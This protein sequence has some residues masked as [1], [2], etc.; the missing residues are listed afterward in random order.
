MWHGGHAGTVFGAVIVSATVGWT[1][2]AV[3][4][5]PEMRAD[6]VRSTIVRHD[7]QRPHINPTPRAGGASQTITVSVPNIVALKLDHSGRITSAATN[8][9]RAPAPG[10]LV[11]VV[12]ADGS[13]QPSAV[14]LSGQRW[15]GDFSTSM[16]F[17]RQSVG[18]Q[19]GRRG[20]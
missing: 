13:Y 3:A 18:E 9:G 2:L 14:D 7:D 19:S 1:G 20:D 16:E 15:T 17:Q 11:Y 8:S 12:G 5:R 4:S 6:T 10:D